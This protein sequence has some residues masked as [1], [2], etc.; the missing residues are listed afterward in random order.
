MRLFQKTLFLNKQFLFLKTLFL[1]PSQHLQKLLFLNNL[2]LS[3]PLTNQK[4]FHLIKSSLTH[5]HHNKHPQKILNIQKISFL[6]IQKMLFLNRHH[7]TINHHLCHLLFLM[8]SQKQ[9]SFLRSPLI[10]LP[11]LRTM[12]HQQK[13]LK[14]VIDLT[15]T[16]DTEPLSEHSSYTT[17]SGSS[18]HVEDFMA[19]LVP[20]RRPSF[21]KPTPQSFIHSE[22]RVSVPSSFFASCSEPSPP[23]LSVTQKKPNVGKLLSNFECE[24]KKWIAYLNKKCSESQNP[25]EAQIFFGQFRRKFNSVASKLQDVCCKNALDKLF[26]TIQTRTLYLKNSL[27]HDA[28]TAFAERFAAFKAA[29]LL[30]PDDTILDED[31]IIE[32]KKNCCRR[33]CL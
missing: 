18:F 32:D 4:L 10:D 22:T 19:N 1:K 31:I 16:S 3:H 11:H 25:I 8:T 5:N 23:N 27:E 30:F 29:E 2:L 7:K 15:L 17:S 6:I 20:R 21:P 24:M 12:S 13:T 28:Y 26:K 9:I 33:A 14:T